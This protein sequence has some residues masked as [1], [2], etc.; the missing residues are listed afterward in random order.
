MN[1]I[2]NKRLLFLPPGVRKGK[3][4]EPKCEDFICFQQKPLGQGA[5]G[6][7]FKVQH[8]ISNK[9]FAIKVIKKRKI[10]ESEAYTSVRNILYEL[11]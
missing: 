10:I 6:E 7:V 9:D 3:E 5:F 1:E 11:F 4:R 8:K 2:S